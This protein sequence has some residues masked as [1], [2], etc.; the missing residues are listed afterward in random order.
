MRWLVAAAAVVVVAAGTGGVVAWRWWHT[1]AAQ[2]R[3]VAT[4]ERFVTA[5]EA[6]DEEALAAATGG[7]EEA[8]RV[9]MDTRAR[10]APEEVEVGLAD[11][12][13][14]AAGEGRA[15]ATYEA[16][17]DLGALGTWT[18]RAQLRLR[19]R[20]A[21]DSWFVA[22]T[23]T[24]LHAQLQTG[25][26]IERVSSWPPRAPITDDE[27]DVL[28][29]PADVLDIGVEPRAVDDADRVA[30]TLAEHTDATAESVTELLQR[31]DLQ[32]AWFY[33]VA[34]LAPDAAAR[35]ALSAVPGVV[36]RQGTGRRVTEPVLARLLGD[37]DEI[38][39]E[40]LDELGEPYDVGDTVGVSGVERAFERR[41]AGEPGGRI[42][43]V[44]E[45]GEPV[46]TLHETEPV[47]PEPVAVTLDAGVQRAADAAMERVGGRGALAAVDVDSGGL[48]AAANRPLGGF[49]RWRA[50]GYP[51]GSTFKVVTA[52]AL[53]DD[54]LA[55]GDTVTCP[56]T[57]TATGRAFENAGDLQLGAISFAEAFA[58]SC[59]TAFIGAAGGLPDGA[60]GAAAGRMGFN[61]S[62]R[63]LG[64]PVAASYP[65]PA[66][67]AELAA[68][69]IGQGR[70]QTAPV[71][72]ASVAAGVAAGTWRQPHVRVS[73]DVA[74]GEPLGPAADRLGSMMRRVVTDGTGTAAAVPGV[75]V[76]GKTGTAEFG[77]DGEHAW[78]IGYARGVAFAVI[79]EDGGS[80]GSVAGPIA[81]EFVAGLP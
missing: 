47:Q 31:D 16:V 54:G 56:A 10:L 13:V 68:Q 30:S 6:G 67:G 64:T 48:L 27:G 24:A 62:Y 58:R 34:Q 65:E 49:P 1:Q 41:L 43:V 14:S 44:G 46:E 5:W 28:A 33:P 7:D 20:D 75:A 42:R 35:A 53:L 60:L 52:L 40:R 38:T 57:V 25:Q 39:A 66:D 3:A 50:G 21:G 61:T 73:A 19:R 17:W 18:H 81:A 11:V 76:H 15:S 45:D 59:N 80:G 63:I 4:A 51:P 55:P 74:A 36:V 26:R 70:V 12:D 72:M 32:P 79:V 29:G 69:V 37:V 22:W 9:H 2:D 71:H 78:F 8:V 77:E 23:P